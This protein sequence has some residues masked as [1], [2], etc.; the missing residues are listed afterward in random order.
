MPMLNGLGQIL[1][2]CRASAS[3][4][5]SGTRQA[6]L[7]LS[8][9]NEHL[10]LSVEDE[11]SGIDDPVYTQLQT[12]GFGLASIR[13]RMTHLGGSAKIARG[14]TGGLHIFLH[15]PLTSLISRPESP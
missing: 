6:R 3:T 8:Q 11:G 5:H 7:L 10:V 9:D 12:D 1:T 2:K 13:E 4:K 14:P 15:L